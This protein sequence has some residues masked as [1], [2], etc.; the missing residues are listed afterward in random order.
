[1][2]NLS[3]IVKGKKFPV[4]VNREGLFEASIGEPGVEEIVS[5]KTFEEIKPLIEKVFKKAKVNVTIEISVLNER[6]RYSGN[7]SSYVPTV[8]H[9]VLTGIHSKSRNPLIKLDGE[10]GEQFHSY[11]SSLSSLLTRLSAD[12]AT[13]LLAQ[14]EII[15][16]AQETIGRIKDA[17]HLD[18]RTAVE[19][20]LKEAGV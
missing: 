10:K 3:V 4:E 19:A 17:H 14:F 1:M 7:R 9:G 16:K 13:E 18:A 11:G 12:E 5:A 8:K 6:D 15:T 20:A 2:A